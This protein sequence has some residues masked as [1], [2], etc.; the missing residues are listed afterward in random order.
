M[1][2]R[3]G[4]GIAAAERRHSWPGAHKAAR[5]GRPGRTAAN[6]Q[7][8]SRL[9]SNCLGSTRPRGYKS[10][11]VLTCSTVL[12][13][14][15]T[16][17]RRSCLRCICPPGRNAQD[18]AYANGQ[19][20]PA[21]RVSRPLGAAIAQSARPW[22]LLGWKAARLGFDLQLR[23]KSRTY[24]IALCLPQQRVC[25][26]GRAAQGKTHNEWAKGVSRLHWRGNCPVPATQGG[27]GRG[28]GKAGV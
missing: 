10:S 3:L 19:G 14:E 1:Q 4:K 6:R 15:P 23:P 11:G 16:A 17:L 12:K 13:A 26:P 27:R 21:S 28:R 20:H 7:R 22:A 25:R 9:Y 5:Q 2:R 24:G 18:R 8:V